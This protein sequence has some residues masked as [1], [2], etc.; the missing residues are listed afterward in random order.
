MNSKNRYIHIGCHKCGSTFIQE[1]LLPKL[2]NI[3]PA[4]FYNYNYLL[5]EFL[6]IAQCADLYYDNKVEKLI[7]DHLNKKDNLFISMEALSGIHYNV[8]TGGFLIKNIANRL[9]NIFPNSKILIVIRNQKDIIESYYKD[10][11]KLGFLGDYESWF[12]WRKQSCQLNYFKYFEL[13]KCYYDIFGSNNVKVMLYENLFKKDY[14]KKSL[15][16]IGI[17]TKG[18]KNV[19]FNKRFNQT[20]SPLSLRLTPIINRFFGS[21]ITYGVNIGKDPRLKAY[22]FWR[23]NMSKYLDKISFLLRIKKINFNFNSYQEMLYDE[24]HQNNQKL[25]ELVDIDINEHNYL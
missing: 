16:E 15:K 5:D 18:I 8:F 11:I 6:Y 25:S 19:N 9:Y 1:E 14:L 17:N 12:K 2:Q 4:T 7:Y 10:D 13:V 23:D 21:K 24:F 20:I 22:Y 3:T